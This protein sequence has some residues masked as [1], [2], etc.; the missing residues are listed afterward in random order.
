MFLD[1]IKAEQDVTPEEWAA[2]LKAVHFKYPSMT[3]KAFAQ[4]KDS[5]QKSSYQ[6]LADC[7]PKP[8]KKIVDLAC[9][10]GYLT[11]ILC[12][13]APSAKIVGIDMADGELDVARAKYQTKAVSFV[14]ANADALPFGNA[15]IDAVV[16]HMALMLMNPIEPVVAE[17]RRVLKPGGLFA[18]V[19]G[20][21]AD[22]GSLCL[23]IQKL[24]TGFIKDEFNVSKL[25][26]T[27]DA[28][29]SSSAGIKSLFAASGFRDYKSQ[30]IDLNI[31]VTV[32]RAQMQ[33]QDTYFVSAMPIEV[34]A[35][36][37]ERVR[38]FLDQKADADGKVRYTYPL[39]LI[40][41]TKN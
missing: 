9:G 1:R 32:N 25:P 35:R 8:A 21:P 7:L 27:G 37:L 33:W 16:S 31:H 19:V 34:K 22:E 4:Y 20:R 12:A 14:N 17:L 10:D 30:D 6:R 28:R 23:G 26:M 13:H 38:S 15:S 18:A 29:V 5:D 11:S 24:I 39:R 41:I 3:S 40:Q 2:F 36:L